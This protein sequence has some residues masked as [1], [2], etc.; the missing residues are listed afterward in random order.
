MIVPSRTGGWESAQCAMGSLLVVAVPPVLG[1]AP[2]LVEA[3]EDVAVEHLGAVGLVEAFDVGVLG[4][5]AGLDVDEF[6]ATILRPLLEHC[7][8]ELG[9]I[10]QA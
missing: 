7:T 8:D 9:P 1:H 5:F 2:H 4:R 10:V 6:D 3:G